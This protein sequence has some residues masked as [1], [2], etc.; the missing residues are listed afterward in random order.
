VTLARNDQTEGQRTVHGTRDQR[1]ESLTTYNELLSFN[2]EPFTLDCVFMAK[3]AP[4]ADRLPKAPLAEVVF[5][6]RWALQSDPASPPILRTD[7]GLVPLLNGF[8]N[9]IKKAG[10]TVYND[11]SPPSQTG[12]YGVARRFYLSADKPFPIMQIGP[13]IFASNASSLYEWKSFKAQ[14]NQG[15]RQLL[16]SYPQL[17]FFSF[18]PNYL[19]LRYID[20]FD[21]SLLGRTDLFILPTK[22]Q[23]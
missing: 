10:Y 5:E 4:S 23:P 1:F 9:R 21:K 14:I 16:K 6:L 20:V 22:A 15:L 8:T 11:M 18:A 17:G 13:G 3:K 7:P 12:A 2:A 19:E